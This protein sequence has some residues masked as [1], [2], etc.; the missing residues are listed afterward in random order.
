[1][2]LT[3]GI[4]IFLLV[5][6]VWLI[7]AIVAGYRGNVAKLRPPEPQL[8]VVGLTLLLIVAGRAIGPF[9]RWL[10]K[11][12]WR[13]IVS[14]HLVRFVGFYFLWLGHTGD[15]NPKFAVP[16]GVGDAAVAV[17]AL[18]LLLAGGLVERRPRLLYSWNILGLLEIWLVVV[19]A[20]RCGLES[21]ESMG[22]LLRLPL[23][24]F[25]TFFVPLIIASHLLLFGR[26]AQMR[27]AQGGN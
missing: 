1:M 2:T 11:L 18:A 16:S 27:K 14:L 13:A 23:S 20:G 12:D 3:G 5:G 25:P 24:L 8:V 22:A 21:P 6:I 15:L 17:T 26:V 4:V 7:A 9:R 19:M 10:G